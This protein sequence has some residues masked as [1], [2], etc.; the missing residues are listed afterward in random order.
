MYV[1]I[2]R[3]IHIYFFLDM[4][5]SA[6]EDFGAGS[7]RPGAPMARSARC[8]PSGPQWKVMTTGQFSLLSA[9]GHETTPSAWTKIEAIVEV[10]AWVSTQFLGGLGGLGGL[11]VWHVSMVLPCAK[12]PYQK[13]CRNHEAGVAQIGFPQGKP[14]VS[15]QLYSVLGG[16]W[17]TF[18]NWRWYP[19]WVGWTGKF[20]RLF[21]A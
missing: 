20:I 11:D 16:C 15:L 10:L 5:V 7:A 13:I 2:Y 17:R 21:Q 9:A 3:N 4:A 19:K 1:Y 8:G 6:C 12:S 14:W 18:V